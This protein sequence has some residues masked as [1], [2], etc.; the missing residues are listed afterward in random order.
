[1]LAARVLRF[2]PALAL[3]LML[4]ATPVGAQGLSTSAPVGRAFTP[5]AIDPYTGIATACRLDV[6]L[7]RSLRHGPV[8]YCRAGLAYEPGALECY[9]FIDEVCTIFLPASAGLTE[10]R[11]SGS[12]AV[13]PCPD[14]PA[15]PVC[16]RFTLR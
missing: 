2:L 15:P 16:P 13:F 4:A 6:R 3:S 5:P 8:D 9:Q 14:A 12:P 1:M 7:F 10:A 11:R